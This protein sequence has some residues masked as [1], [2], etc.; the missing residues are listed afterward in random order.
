MKAA[1]VKLLASLP[2]LISRMLQDNRKYK[3]TSN[4]I[5]SIEVANLNNIMVIAKFP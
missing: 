5:N 1:K 3:T 2:E 4:D